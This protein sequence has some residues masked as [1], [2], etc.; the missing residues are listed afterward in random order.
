MSETRSPDPL[1]RQ[2]PTIDMDA[3][4]VRPVD[5]T[6]SVDPKSSTPGTAPDGET[7]IEPVATMG[8]GPDPFPKGAA[9][10]STAPVTPDQSKPASGG[11]AAGTGV[12]SP[13][14]KPSDSSP[15]TAAGSAIGPKPAAPDLKPA[16]IDPKPAGPETRSALPG[17]TTK[18]SELT[19]TLAAVAQPGPKPATA[20]AK[21]SP[22]AAASTVPPTKPASPEAKPSPSPARST[23]SEQP[24]TT[25]SPSAPAPSRSSWPAALAAGIVGAILSA[26]AVWF[27]LR[28]GDAGFGD[29]VAAL[30][31]R[32]A[33][34]P[35]GNPTAALEPRLA[36][37]DASVRQAV[38]EA[39]AAKAAADAAARQAAE[40]PAAPP[41]DTVSKGVL[42]ALSARVED[43]GRQAGTAATGLGDLG[44]KF[45]ALATRTSEGL[46]AAATATAAV[47]AS[48]TGL[49]TDSTT[50]RTGLAST[51][52]RL[53]EGEKKLATIGTALDGVTGD[54]AR[55]QPA[56]SQAGLRIAVSGRLD[57]ALRTGAPVG[58]PLGALERLGVEAGLLAPL[59]PYATAPAPSAGTLLAEFRPMA[60]ALT[61]TPRPAEESLLDKLRRLLFKVVTVRAVGDGSGADLPG[62]VARIEAALGRGAVGEAAAAWERLP[63]AARRSTAAWGERLKG[64]A[65]ADDA[66]RRIGAQALAGLETV[67]R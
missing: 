50:I 45:D 37:L 3:K 32:V 58:P 42:D 61:A 4:E 64:R 7:A 38:D 52:T 53:G 63:E 59:R 66:A 13:S 10:S 11:P 41:A 31:R 1:R 9:R 16:A 56:A 55:L 67:T 29:R 26:A 14:S 12:T 34:L 46:A 36:A 49:Q 22:A 23:V 18:A 27:L 21:P 24:K 62:L 54:L 25:P 40:R 47:A 8:L 30:E 33:S 35:T 48:V 43:V 51:E 17:T 57:D 15:S 5:P 2:P 60:D 19:K 65:A 20:G 44:Q 28:S 6:T 39:R